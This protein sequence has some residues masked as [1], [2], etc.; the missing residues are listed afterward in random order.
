MATLTVSFMVVRVVVAMVMASVV[1]VSGM[2][3]RRLW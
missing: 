2:V 3:G 1:I